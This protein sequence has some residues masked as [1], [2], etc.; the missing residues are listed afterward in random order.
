VSVSRKGSG[1]VHDSRPDP[2]LFFACSSD[3]AF[4]QGGSQ[5]SSS[6]FVWIDTATQSSVCTSLVAGITKNT[7][8][9]I[10]S[11]VP[12]DFRQPFSVFYDDTKVVD[13]P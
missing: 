13:F 9:T 11:G 1:K 2:S 12:L 8:I 3:L 6:D 5:F 4:I 10:D 7:Q